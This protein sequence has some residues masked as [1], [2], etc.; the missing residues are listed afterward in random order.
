MIKH[1]ANVIIL[2]IQFRHS[3]VFKHFL[4]FEENSSEKKWRK[5]AGD[6]PFGKSYLIVLE[7]KEVK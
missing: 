6:L 7:L 5:I 1:L 3:S 4:R 2:L